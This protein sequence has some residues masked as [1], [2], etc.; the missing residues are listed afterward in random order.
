VGSQRRR[1]KYGIPRIDDLRKTPAQIRFLS[2]EPL[3]E[4][5]GTINLAGIHWA[6][7]GGESG[8]GAPGGYKALSDDDW[9][10]AL[11]VNLLAFVRSIEHSCPA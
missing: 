2:I 11:N 4:D 1:R 8:P 7:V 6:I 5:L 3:L 10:K 9:Q